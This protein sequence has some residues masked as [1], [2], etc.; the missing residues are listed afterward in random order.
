MRVPWR[1]VWVGLKIAF[2]VAIKL[3]DAGVIKVKEL[4]TVKTVKD[5]IE[6]EVAA[7]KRP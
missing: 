1:K 4:G 2:G 3:N 6:G 7:V 5:A